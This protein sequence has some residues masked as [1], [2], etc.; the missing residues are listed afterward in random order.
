MKVKSY[1]SGFE[2]IYSE[3]VHLNND[4][5][6]IEVDGLP[7][8]IHFRTDSGGQRWS[9]QGKGK[10][11]DLYL[12]NLLNPLPEGMFEPLQFANS[13]LV[14]LYLT[15]HSQLLDQVKKHR[16]FSY[17]VLIKDKTNA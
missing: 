5:L 8:Y 17:A 10:S 9:I 11:V 14:D 16:V 3:T 12:Y 2:V 13:S 7:L 15:F 4:E 6:R 1:V